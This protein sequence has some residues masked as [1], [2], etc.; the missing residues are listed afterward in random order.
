MK[1]RPTALCS[2]FELESERA[3]DERGFFTRLTDNDVLEHLTNGAWKSPYSAIS[4]NQ[5]RHTLRG[6]HWQAA[7]ALET[8]LVRCVAGSIFDVVVNVDP[9]T[10]EYGQWTAV[11][12]D[13]EAFNAV[14]IPPNHA[15]G[16]LTL[17]EGSRVLYEILGEYRPE[18]SRT[19]HW[20]DKA[21][22][23]DWPSAPQ[24]VGARDAVAGSLHEVMSSQV[25][26]ELTTTENFDDR[27]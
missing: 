14:F 23:I 4:H 12:L 27:G 6:L 8:K 15:H 11:V 22:G 18:H 7:P 20:A 16:Y 24:I 10:N 26:T 2:V 13:S 17:E 1:I 21:L 19:C 5:M 3:G 25:S 9:T